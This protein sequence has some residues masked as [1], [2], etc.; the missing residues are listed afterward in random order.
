MGSRSAG[1]GNRPAFRLH[2]ASFESRVA[3]GALDVLVLFIIASLFVTAGSLIVLIS[4]DFERVEPSSTAL[5]AFWVCVALIPVAFLLYFFIGL[6]WKGQTVGAAVM[7]LMVVRSDGRP[8]GVLGAMARVIG[9][10]AY[11][12]LAGIGIVGAYALR[13]STVAAGAVLAAALVLAALGILWAAFD[14]HRRTL[15]DRLAGTI[16]VRLV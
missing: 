6:A 15:H 3:A 9:L 13:E 4:S 14:R 16:V 7:Q 11:V 5:S 8:L 10:L 12:L 1:G 2:Y